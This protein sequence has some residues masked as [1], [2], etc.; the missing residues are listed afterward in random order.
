MVH[1]GAHRRA[2]GACPKRPLKSDSPRPT[3]TCPDPSHVMWQHATLAGARREALDQYCSA[4]R[5]LNGI[6][7]TGKALWRKRW[8]SASPTRPSPLFGLARDKNRRGL[9]IFRNGCDAERH[10]RANQPDD[11]TRLCTRPER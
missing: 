3:E 11:C 8:K 9:T 4:N 7:G 10:A 1:I 6:S 5:G 2:M